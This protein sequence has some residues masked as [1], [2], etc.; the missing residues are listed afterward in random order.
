MKILVLG[1]GLM[2]PAAAYNAMQDPQVSQVTLA[3][4]SEAQLAVART[5][6]ANK[7][8]SEKLTIVPLDLNDQTAGCPVDGAT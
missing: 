1:G 5:K 8:A 6:L 3:D 7:P 4:M 2:G